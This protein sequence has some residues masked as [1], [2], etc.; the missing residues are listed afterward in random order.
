LKQAEAC[1]KE[2]K[3]GERT[4]PDIEMAVIGGPDQITKIGIELVLIGVI[5]IGFYSRGFWRTSSV[6]WNWMYFLS[7]TNNSPA[8]VALNGRDFRQSCAAWP[9]TTFTSF[10]VYVEVV[11]MR[12]ITVS[13]ALLEVLLASRLA[14]HATMEKGKTE[15]TCMVFGSRFN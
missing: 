14:P 5:Y 2:V 12:F 4:R 11:L 3:R 13:H 7:S 10:V 8:F 6:L 9:S 1:S 15:A